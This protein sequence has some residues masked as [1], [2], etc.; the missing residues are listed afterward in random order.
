MDARIDPRCDAK[1]SDHLPA[2]VL[3][4]GTSPRPTART[5]SPGGV[6]YRELPVHPALAEDVFCYW[7]LSSAE[8]LRSPI[9]SRGLSKGYLDLIFPSSGHFCEGAERHL[10]GADKLG[11]YLVGPLSTP[12]SITSSGRCE[13]V[14]VRF[15]PGRA[16][17]FFRVSLCELTDRVATFDCFDR[18][19]RSL[20]ETVAAQDPLTTKL[21][22]LDEYLLHRKARVRPEETVLT[23]AVQMIERHHGALTVEALAGALGRGRRQLERLFCDAVGLSPKH[24]SRVVRVQ[25][26]ISLLPAQGPVD[27]HELVHRCGFYDQ[28]HFIRDFRAITGLTPRAFLAA[29]QAAG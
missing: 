28:A 4:T 29:V 12:A 5:C 10:F 8:P 23:R 16:R 11:G 9:V 22:A 21:A 20:A 24:Y 14:G 3:P 13:T 2:V 17:P 6:T 15:R 26:A 27:W 19:A 1:T 18:D 25:H 7:V